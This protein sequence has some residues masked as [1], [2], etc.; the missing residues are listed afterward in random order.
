MTV[1]GFASS[2]GHV[3]AALFWQSNPQSSGLLW[4]VVWTQY[5]GD[6]SGQAMVC[7]ERNFVPKLSGF[8]AISINRG[9]V[10][11]E[12]GALMGSVLTLGVKAFVF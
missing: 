5:L 12:Y 9:S 3:L 1:T 7:L 6:H 10:R 8:C 2:Q 4:R 11:T